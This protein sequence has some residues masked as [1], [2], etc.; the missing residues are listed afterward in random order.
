MRF[1]GVNVA[2]KLKSDIAI[3]LFVKQPKLQFL[4]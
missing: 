1:C 3:A 4:P 2:S